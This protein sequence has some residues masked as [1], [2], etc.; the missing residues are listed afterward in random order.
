MKSIIKVSMVLVI[1]FLGSCS[2]SLNYY[3]KS[4]HEDYQLSETELKSVQFYLS[5]NIVLYRELGTHESKITE[6]KIKIENG[7]KI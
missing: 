5:K 1:A 4:M 6:G 3:T 7:R 2:P